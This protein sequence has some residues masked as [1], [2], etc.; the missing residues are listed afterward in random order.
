MEIEGTS[1]VAETIHSLFHF[2]TD[3]KTRLD[4]S[5]TGNEQ[6][7]ALLSMELL[8]LDEV[9]MIDTDVWCAMAEIL[10]NVDHTRRPEATRSDEFGSVHMILFGDFKCPIARVTCSKAQRVSTR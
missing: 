10:S 2:D 9:S 6:V 8:L 4:L 1:V 5:N 7:A 3:L